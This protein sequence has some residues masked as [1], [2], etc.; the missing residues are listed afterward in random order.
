MALGPNQPPIQWVSGALS[1]GV[2]RL[3]READHSPPSSAEVK[4]CVELYLHS[5][6]VFTAWCLVKYRDYFTFIIFLNSLNLFSCLG[7]D[8]PRFPPYKTEIITFH[9]FTLRIL[10][11]E[12]EYKWKQAF[13]ELNLV[14]TS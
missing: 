6:Y 11:R 9:Y 4:E 3:R 1:L 13:Y 2:K 14:L 10:G 12:Q 7:D 8:R 5:Q